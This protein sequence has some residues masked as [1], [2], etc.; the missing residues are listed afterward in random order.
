MLYRP[1]AIAILSRPRPSLVFGGFSQKQSGALEDISFP[2]FLYINVTST[3]ET[4][5][6]EVGRSLRSK[7]KKLGEKN[8]TLK[9]IT[10][11]IRC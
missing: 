9:D 11:K 6:K 2:L 7:P 5:A 8:L 10:V 1:A 4:L 3:S